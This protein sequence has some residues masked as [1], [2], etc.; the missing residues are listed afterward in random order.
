MIEEGWGK[1]FNNN[2]GS[3]LV[4]ENGNLRIKSWNVIGNYLLEIVKI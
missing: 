2:Q 4:P 3:V 1:I